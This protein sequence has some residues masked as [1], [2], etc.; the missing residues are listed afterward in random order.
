MD[1]NK[2]RNELKNIYIKYPEFVK[3]ISNYSNNIEKIQ[4]WEE[5][6]YFGAD[7]PSF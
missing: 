3:A 4:K 7:S 1:S 6:V 5:S 2:F